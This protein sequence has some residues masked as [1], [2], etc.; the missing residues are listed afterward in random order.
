MEMLIEASRT[1]RSEAAIHRVVDV[2]IMKRAID[3]R[4]APTRK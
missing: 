2:G 3:A 4:I 1:Q